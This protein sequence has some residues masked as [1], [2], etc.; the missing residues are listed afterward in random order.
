MI[1]V[2]SFLFIVQQ[3]GL[4]PNQSINPSSFLQINHSSAILVNDLHEEFWL[5]DEKPSVKFM[6]ALA[7]NFEALLQIHIGPPISIE[8]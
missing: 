5:G 1:E 3:L 8:H 4:V 7:H 2:S 6:N